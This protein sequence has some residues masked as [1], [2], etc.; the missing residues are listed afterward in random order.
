MIYLDYAAS[1]PLRPGALNV[2][3]RSMTEDYANPSSAHALGSELHKRIEACRHA[4]LKFLGASPRDHFFFTGSATESNNTAIHGIAWQ[5]GDSVWVSSAEHPSLTAPVDALKTH[6]V[7]VKD[8]PL[9]P[10]GTPDEDAFLPLLDETVKLV[11][12]SH[13]NNQSG[14]ITDFLH[15]AKKIRKIR[16]SK[17]TFPVHIH[18]DA[19][20]SFGKLPFSLHEGLIDTLSVSAHKMGG[21]KGIAGL[22]VRN[23][24]SL[25]PLLLG[26]GQENGMRSATQ[27]APLIVSFCEAAREAF[28]TLDE[29]RAHVTQINVLAHR[30]LTDAFPSAQ[31]PFFGET[32]SPY[33]L[34]FVLPGIS[35]DIIVRHLE[36]E[37]IMISSSSACSSKIKGKNPVFSALHLPEKNHKFVLR[38]SFSPLTTPAE[39]ETFG[40]TL[41]AIYNNLTYFLPKR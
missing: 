2:L 9:R 14:A 27:A 1:G 31:F 11:I 16:K 4:F 33:I 20:Q 28:A 21:P 7:T 6:G 18:V 38:V 17:T 8:L 41:A 26:G 36:K 3:I 25:S 40:R 15:L 32:A 34:T 24:V 22:Y 35:S 10:D 19:A 29:A 39:V 12:V 23:G 5:A 37:G 30:Q 13:V